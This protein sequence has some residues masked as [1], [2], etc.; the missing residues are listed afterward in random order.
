MYSTSHTE[1]FVKEL[2]TSVG[3]LDPLQLNIKII[4]SKL[5]IRVFYWHEPSQAIFL[6]NY[7]YIVLNSQQSDQAMWQDFC[8]ELCH[9]LFHS[10][11]QR[12]IRESFRQYQ[13]AKANQFMYHA[14]IPSFMLDELN[15]FDTTYES[16]RKVC[17]L[18][19]VEYEFASKRLTKYIFNKLLC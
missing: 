17:K 13:E 9:V 1:D 3:I 19:N 10:G 5:E 7:P 12:R 14:C 16:I 6:N 8:H 2:Y 11:N 4:S 18:F 15:I